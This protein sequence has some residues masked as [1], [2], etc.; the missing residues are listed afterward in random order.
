MS[1]SSFRDEESIPEAAAE[2]VSNCN[3]S[4]LQEVRIYDYRDFP[5]LVSASL[6]P[7]N[8]TLVAL[9]TSLDPSLSDHRCSTI[10]DEDQVPNSFNQRTSVLYQPTFIKKSSLD[11]LSSPNQS[12]GGCF[13]SLL[14]NEKS[15]ENTCSLKRP[16]SNIY[17]FNQINT[18]SYN[19][20]GFVML[21]T[22]LH[23][24]PLPCVFP[25][26]RFAYANA[27]R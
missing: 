23:S 27:L 16:E 26:A 19:Q 14:S 7:G 12:M 22:C 4:S 24:M 13:C 11:D 1:S 2:N 9:A 10:V 8:S 6:V 5:N 3:G 21:V 15:L 20:D 18:Y 25:K 17:S